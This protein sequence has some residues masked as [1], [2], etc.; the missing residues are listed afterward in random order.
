MKPLPLALI[1]LSLCFVSVAQT[2]PTTI[3]CTIS[4]VGKVNY[5][6]LDKL[7]PDSIKT[8]LLVDPRKQFKFR[9]AENVLLWMSLH[10][11]KLVSAEASVGGI[12]GNVSSSTFY[13]L[14]R[15]INLDE[16]ARA[17]LIQRLESIENK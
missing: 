15:E 5:G 2:Q 10:G 12:G 17:L 9:N 8:S 11:W 7:L 14:S 1:L 6:N 3:Y 16:T 13:L 4:D